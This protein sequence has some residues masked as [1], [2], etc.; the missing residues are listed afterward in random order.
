MQERA[1]LMSL[2]LPQAGSWLTVAPILALGLHMRP[3]EFVLVARLRL[4]IELFD[5]D[6]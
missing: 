1:H 3:Q 5:T 6:R 2:G 4:G